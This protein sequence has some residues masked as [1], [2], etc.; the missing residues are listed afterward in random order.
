MAYDYIEL[1]FLTQ[2]TDLTPIIPALS[3]V[4]A[5]ALGASVAE[6]NF[7]S[8]TDKLSEVM[9]DYPFRVP[10][11]YALIIRSLVTLEGIAINLDPNFKV[12]SVAYPYV[13]GRLLSDPSPELRKTLR[14]LLF[15]EGEFR[16]NRLENLLRNA[17]N[18]RDFNLKDSLEKALDFIFSERG[19]FLRER[20]VEVVFSRTQQGSSGMDHLQRVWELLSKNPSFQPME[21][22]PAMVKVAARPEAQ[23]LGLDLASRW[24][25]REAAQL[26][27]QMFVDDHLL[28]R[29]ST[30]GAHKTTNTSSNN[31][32]RPR[33][34]Q[35]T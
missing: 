29:P 21:L 9:Y 22:V 31:G 35:S 26:L 15:R 25:Q 13:A 17:S 3:Q 16:W 32:H 6:L 24:L 23:T 18:S 7:K 30:N 34:P 33:L 27:R 19:E 12:L 5:E 4:F 11:Y 14:E 1:G 28:P 10:A 2:D 8:I 20:L